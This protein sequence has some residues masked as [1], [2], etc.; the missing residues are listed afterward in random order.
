MVCQKPSYSLSHFSAVHVFYETPPDRI[1]VFAVSIGGRRD[2]FVFYHIKGRQGVG[3][4]PSP[5]HPLL[6]HG[7]VFGFLPD[8]ACFVKVTFTGYP[9][10][11]LAGSCV[12]IGIAHSL[13]AFGNNQNPFLEIGRAHV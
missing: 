12:Y 9:S 10:R 11:F 2:H 6:F 4:M 1:F 5:E 3:G 7:N 13:H 8:T